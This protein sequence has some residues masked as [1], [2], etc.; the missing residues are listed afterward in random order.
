MVGWAP[1]VRATNA[2]PS[3]CTRTATGTIRNQATKLC[4][5]TP[6]YQPRI[7]TMMTNEMSMVT[8]K[9]NSR[10]RAIGRPP[11]TIGIVMTRA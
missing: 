8:G 6:G 2:C 5:S 11:W 10:N 1:V 3:S 9:P 4:A 7:A